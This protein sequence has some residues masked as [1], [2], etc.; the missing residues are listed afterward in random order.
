MFYLQIV[1]FVLPPA[2]TDPVLKVCSA[3]T[4]PVGSS[5]EPA[6]R[7]LLGTVSSA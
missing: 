3:P 6:H 5:V 1:W 7:V 4:H 2:M